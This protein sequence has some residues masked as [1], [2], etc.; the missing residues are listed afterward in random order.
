MYLY[1]YVRLMRQNHKRQFIFVIVWRARIYV[2]C[3]KP[4]FYLFFLKNEYFVKEII[5]I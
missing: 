5:L 2:I 4:T 1:A 3:F